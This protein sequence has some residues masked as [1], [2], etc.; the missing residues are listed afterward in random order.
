LPRIWEIAEQTPLQTLEWLTLQVP[1]NKVA[2]AWVLQSLD[3]WILYFLVAHSNMRVRSNAAQLLISLVP[4]NS[5][6]QNYR[7]SRPFP[8][9][10][11][12]EYDFSSEAVLI[13]DQIYNVLLQLLKRVKTYADPQTHGTQKLTSYF[14]VMSYCLISQRQKLLLVP[15]FNDLWNL[16][17]PKLSEPA[18]SIHHNKQ[19]L[20]MFWFMACQDCPENVKCIVQNPHVTKNIAFNYILADHDDQEVVFFNKMMLPNYYGLLRLCCQ[21]SRPFTRLLAMHQNIQWAFKNITPYITQYQMAVQEL[22]KLM[23]IFV[24]THS[25]ST[26]QEIREITQ[27]KR[28]TITMYLT[29]IDVRSS[30]QTL[31]NALSILVETEE[32]RIFVLQNNGLSNL[33]Q[34]FHAMH[35]MFHEATACHIT[36]ELVDLLKIIVSLLKTLAN[37]SEQIQLREIKNNWRDQADIMRKNILLVNSY[38]PSQVR[39]ACLGNFILQINCLINKF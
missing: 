19:A 9:P 30:W 33:F 13:I 38:T 16:F 32:D 1:R 34:S 12:K 7:P 14:I 4:N 17:Q 15:Y 3:S 22:F 10:G 28:M 5:F 31:I 35:M 37:N 18:I 23:K 11:I 6:R 21:Q 36:N 26:E 29:S 27:F 20:L 8:Y 25:E 24:T 39:I 2:N